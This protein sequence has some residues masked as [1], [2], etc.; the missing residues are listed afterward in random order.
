MLYAD[1]FQSGDDLKG[2]GSEK[3]FLSFFDLLA[4]Y[5][6]LFKMKYINMLLNLNIRILKHRNRQIQHYMTGRVPT[7]APTVNEVR[8][9][10]D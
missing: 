3:L 5:G 9:A 2:P 1:V 10:S 7:L 4:S 8:A 6:I